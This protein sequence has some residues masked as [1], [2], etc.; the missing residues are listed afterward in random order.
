MF[1]T[2]GREHGRAEA[3]R[4]GVG[5]T[6]VAAVEDWGR[7]RGCG[8]LKAET[9]NVNVPACRLYE[10]LGFALREANPRAYPE[11]PEE[12]QLLWYKSLA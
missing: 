1:T 3:R 6:L 4:Q 2:A 10:K 12:I 9:Q 11:L 8:E 5:R 7:S